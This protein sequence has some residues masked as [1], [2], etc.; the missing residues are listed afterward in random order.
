MEKPNEQEKKRKLQLR[1]ETLVRLLKEE[2]LANVRGGI[3]FDP[4]L[5]PENG[6]SGLSQLPCGI[7]Y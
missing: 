4:V 3:V 6:V 1:T 2:E 7:D 5:V